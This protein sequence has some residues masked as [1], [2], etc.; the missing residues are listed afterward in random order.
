[1]KA[2]CE[3]A[4]RRF[5]ELGCRVE[6]VAPKWPSP[7]AAWRTMF[8]GGIAARLGPALRERRDDIDA[9]LVAIADETRSW[10]PTQYVQAW[11]DRLAWEE[12]PRAAL[13]ALRPAAD[14]DDRVRGLQ[15]RPRRP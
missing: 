6:E 12:H 4:A 9:G 13:R 14:A 2:A 11:F 5:R 8:L 7:Q 15:G 3:R 1:M 10:S